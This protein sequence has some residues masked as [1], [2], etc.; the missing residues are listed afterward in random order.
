MVAEPIQ[1]HGRPSKLHL[2]GLQT[3]NEYLR[4]EVRALRD[5]RAED[6]DAIR[7]HL[8]RLEIVAHEYGPAAMASVRAIEARLERMSRRDAGP[9]AA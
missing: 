9:R 5:E 4:A 3:T 6:V 1:L 8:R 2:N 7:P